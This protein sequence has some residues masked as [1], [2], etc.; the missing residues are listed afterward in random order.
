MWL[1]LSLKSKARG[2]SCWGTRHRYTATPTKSAPITQKNLLMKCERS[3]GRR[4]DH[5]RAFR[6][7][8]F[9][10]GFRHGGIALAAGKLEPHRLAQFVLEH[11]SPQ[12]GFLEAQLCFADVGI[13]LTW[14]GLHPVEAF[15]SASGRD[16]EPLAH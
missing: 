1:S 13:A 7:R 2:S 6:R 15:A 8:E 16:V 5:V 10:I 3:L 12:V 14:H 9:H 11:H 4:A